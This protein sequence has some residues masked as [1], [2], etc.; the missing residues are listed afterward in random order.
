[1]ADGCHISFMNWQLCTTCELVVVVDQK[2]GV[3]SLLKRIMTNTLL[4]ATY[5][6]EQPQL[7]SDMKQLKT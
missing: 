5:K 2:A 3:T 1:M 4:N 6:V 7:T